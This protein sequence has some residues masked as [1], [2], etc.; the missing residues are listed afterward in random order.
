ME[1]HLDM[2]TQQPTK[3][4]PTELYVTS[5]VLLQEFLGNLAYL[6][7]FLRLTQ[8]FPGRIFSFPKMLFVLFAANSQPVFASCHGDQLGVVSEATT[9][10]LLESHSWLQI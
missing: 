1:L 3:W 6:R 4:H 9:Q 7:E 8:F 2:L 10:L 5:L